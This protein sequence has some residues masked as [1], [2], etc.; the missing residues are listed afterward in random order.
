MVQ[1]GDDGAQTE[2]EAVGWGG[3][4]RGQ[5]LD[6]L[7]RDKGIPG[8]PRCGA[9]SGTVSRVIPGGWRETGRMVHRGP[10]SRHSPIWSLTWS[11]SL[12]RNLQVYLGKHNIHER[13]SFQEESSVA[14]AVPHPSYNAATHD[15]DIM[16]LRLRRPARLSE[17][18]QPLTLQTDCSANHTTC[19]ILGWGKTQDGQWDDGRWQG[20]SRPPSDGSRGRWTEGSRVKGDR[21][22]MVGQWGSV[23]VGERPG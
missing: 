5:T 17:Y 7:W 19:Q 20:A 12:P 9:C 3:A 10:T 4:R 14:R 13:E 1:V 11:L 16:L 2:T 23:S 21:G 18:I 15:Q 22:L 6:M 8:W